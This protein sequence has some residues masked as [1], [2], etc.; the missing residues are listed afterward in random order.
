MYWSLN[1]VRAILAVCVVLYHLGG[2][3]ALERYFHFDFFARIFGFGGARVPFFF[4]L[5]GF[6]LTLAYAKSLDQPGKVWPFLKKRFIRLYPSYWVILLLVMLPAIF[7]PSLRDAIP[8]DPWQMLKT[9]LLMPQHPSAGWPT[10]APVIVAAWTLH[11]EVVS[12]LV[13]ASWIFSRALGLTLSLLLAANALVCGQWECGFYGEFLSAHYLLYFAF[14]AATAWVAK[15]LPPMKH[16]A[17]LAGLAVAAYL[18]VA[19]ISYEN[20]AVDWITDSNLSFTSMASVILLCL[21]NAEDGRPPERNSAWVKLLSD[22]SYVLYLLH[23]P[24]ISL[25]CKVAMAVGLRGAVGAVLTFVVALLGCIAAAI[26]FHLFIERRL[27][28][29]RWPSVRSAR[30]QDAP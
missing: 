10:G 28:S 4:V 1:S 30:V 8:H 14:G 3:L 6:V 24:V 21:T 15:R 9:W 11:Y 12:Y 18:A 26:V 20:P 16:A 27:V 5:S 22:S 23:Y 17:P 2:T 19:I 25:V 13:L 29:F 7:I